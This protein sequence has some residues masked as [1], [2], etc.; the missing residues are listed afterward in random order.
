FPAA[1]QSAASQSSSPSTSPSSGR[2]RS[3]WKKLASFIAGCG[4]VAFM[5]YGPLSRR[6]I[7]EAAG[8]LQGN[9]NLVGLDFKFD[10][11]GACNN[12]DCHGAAMPSDDYVPS[13]EGHPEAPGYD[14]WY[15][16]KRPKCEFN[17]WKSKDQHA[18]AYK[19][20]KK[21]DVKKNPKFGD[22]AKNMGIAK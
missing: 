22:I 2:A 13:A 19:A 17:V 5:V 14:K 21:P 7:G 3:R 9:A 15:T 11:A 16:D 4:V 20:L 10:G 6:V 1:S 12:A 18:K 8:P